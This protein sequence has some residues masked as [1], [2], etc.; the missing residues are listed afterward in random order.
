MKPNDDI[1]NF[2]LAWRKLCAIR[3]CMDAETVRSQCNEDTMV[4]AVAEDVAVQARDIVETTNKYFAAMI[5]S[6]RNAKS[7]KKCA[8][9]SGNEEIDELELETSEDDAEGAAEPPFGGEELSAADAFDH[10]SGEPD[11]RDIKEDPDEAVSAVAG[12]ADTTNQVGFR[13]EMISEY[14]DLILRWYEKDVNATNAFELVEIDLYREAAAKSGADGSAGSAEPMLHGKKLKDYLFEEIGSRPGGLCKN[15]WGYLLKKNVT[16]VNGRPY[17]SRLRAVANASFRNPVEVKPCDSNGDEV[18]SEPVDPNSLEPDGDV[19][20]L[21]AGDEFKK[22]LLNNWTKSFDVSDRVVLCCAFFEYV[23]S[24]PFVESLVPI[25]KSAL[26]ARKNKRVSQVFSL[27]K[28]KGFEFDTVRK[29]FCGLGQQILETVAV[30]DANTRDDACVKLV[31]Y[32]REKKVSTG[33]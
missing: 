12:S 3:L 18:P 5:R 31:Q 9:E 17:P 33:N 6:P 20:V 22:Y 19:L 11:L 29:L 7:L 25:A 10:F 24:D 23:L 2:W 8:R 15:L 28:R 27:L 14:R 32:F 4:S 16:F 1:T 26:G 30:I 13:G 21:Q